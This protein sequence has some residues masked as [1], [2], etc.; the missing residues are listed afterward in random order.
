MSDLNYFSDDENVDENASNPEESEDETEVNMADAIGEDTDEEI[1]NE[2][3]AEV[4]AEEN[5]D[6]ESLP[7]DL[8]EQEDS[9]EEE[10][11]SYLQKFDREINKNY[12][13]D[14]HPECEIHTQAE[15]LAMAQV[16]RDQYGNI[17]DEFHRT[18]PFITKFERARIIGQRA[19]QINSGS[20]PFITHM[21][22]NMIDGYLIAEMELE[23]KAM[24]FIIRRP[25]P[26][27][28]SEYWKIKDLQNILSS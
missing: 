23:Y 9:D 1:E 6:D 24:P 19:S 11:E 10:E 15:I 27:G 21:P 14:H 16:V 3:K 2:S 5:D 13:I 17:V 22:D 25:L 26:N 20:K 8:A 7:L 28:G 4:D 18:L 12:I